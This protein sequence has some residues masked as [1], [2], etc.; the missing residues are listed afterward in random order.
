M[1][2]KKTVKITYKNDDLELK[3]GIKSQLVFSKLTGRLYKGDTLE[4]NFYIFL[5][6]ITVALGKKPDIDEFC[7]W[8][9]ENPEPFVKFMD[10]LTDIFTNGDDIKDKTE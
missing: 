7:D 1:Q 10:Y 8:V 5:S 6:A 2:M 4:D 3:F 9:D